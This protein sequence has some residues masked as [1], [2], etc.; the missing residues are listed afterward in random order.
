M[1]MTVYLT[2]DPTG[3]GDSYTISLRKNG[4]TV[5]PA[6]TIS[7]GATSGVWKDY[8]AL[9]AGDVICFISNGGVSTPTA[10]RPE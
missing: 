10:N 6:V 3:A 4:A 5:T 9:A 7:A 1:T 2:V 8:Y